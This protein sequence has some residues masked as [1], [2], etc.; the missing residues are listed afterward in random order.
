[1]TVILPAF[2]KIGIC[3]KYI[4]DRR[5][6]KP[7]KDIAKWSDAKD[8]MAYFYDSLYNQMKVDE[9]KLNKEIIKSYLNILI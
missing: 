5:R 7:R 3:I 2:M 1:M 6:A 9:S 8:Y 4:I